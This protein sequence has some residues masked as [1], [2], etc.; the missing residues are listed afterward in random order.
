VGDVAAA[1]LDKLAA[2]GPAVGWVLSAYL[3]FRLHQLTD[4]QHKANLAIVKSLTAIR[5]W[6]SVRFGG[7]PI[8]GDT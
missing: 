4:R 1:L 6:L 3:L 8:G 2:G 7:G 5:V